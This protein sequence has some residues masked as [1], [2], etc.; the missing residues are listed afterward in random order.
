MFIDHISADIIRV[1]GNAYLVPDGDCLYIVSADSNWLICVTGFCHNFPSEIVNLVEQYTNASDVSG[2]YLTWDI[3]CAEVDLQRRQYLPAKSKTVKAL[4]AERHPRGLNAK[5]VRDHIESRGALLSDREADLVDLFN[6]GQAHSVYPEATKGAQFARDQAM[7]SKYIFQHNGKVVAVDGDYFRAFY[8]MGF[9]LWVPSQRYTEKLGMP[10]L[11]AVLEGGDTYALG[12]LPP[13]DRSGIT[14][15]ADGRMLYADASL[16]SWATPEEAQEIIA[17]DTEIFNPLT[18]S[19]LVLADGTE[20][21]VDDIGARATYTSS[22]SASTQVAIGVL[23]WHGVAEHD[24]IA[25]LDAQ[26]FPSYEKAYHKIM[27]AVGGSWKL[28]QVNLSDWE[29]RQM[30][31]MASKARRVL[32]HLDQAGIPAE[33]GDLPALEEALRTHNREAG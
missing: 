20:D 25:L 33:V 12:F 23:R 22:I 29:M 15:A 16:V 27:G 13:L 28:G 10:T 3:L 31:D 18:H 8:D 4:M 30:K 17:G 2:K 9:G 32:A 11:T 26:R 14:T 6:S 7:A 24:I 1:L 19:D 21:R 5:S